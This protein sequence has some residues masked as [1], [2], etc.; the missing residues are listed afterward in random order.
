MTKD[1]ESSIGGGLSCL[2]ETSFHL[3][4]IVN[5]PHPICPKEQF[6]MDYGAFHF[7]AMRQKVDFI[8]KKF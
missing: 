6:S 1:N 3:P 8:D 7:L 5:Y 4:A 2:R